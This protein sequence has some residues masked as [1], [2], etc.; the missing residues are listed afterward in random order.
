MLEGKEVDVKFDGGAGEA[1]VDVDATGK[2]VC[3]V[4]YNKELDLNGFAKVKASNDVSI[5][6]NF[7]D[8][9]GKYVEKTE[10]KIDD[11]IYAGAKSLLALLQAA[12]K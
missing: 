12:G 6:T 1:F 2:V 11:K 4:K 5:E 10:N 8:I 9:L 3:G 7:V